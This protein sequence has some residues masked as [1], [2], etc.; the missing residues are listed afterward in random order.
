MLN[1]L[2]SKLQ[3][4]LER[5]IN[6]VLELENWLLEEL[7]VNA[8]IE[9]EITSS[10]IATYRDTNDRNKRNLHMYN[11]NT[12]QP[13]LK[14]YN[15]KFDQKF[16]DCPFSD[17]LDEQKYGFM[18]KARFVKSEM[19][20]EKNIALSVKE[21][22]LITKYREIMSNISI[23]WEG[24]QKTYAYV[25]A[26]IDNPNRAIREKAWYALCEARSI[27]KIE[28]DCIMKEL[29]QLRNQMAL[30]AGFNNYSE[31]A[32]KQK[33]RDYSIE[34]CYKLHES[35]EK[36]VVPIWKQLGSISK[37]N[38]GV[39]TYR[40]WD[41]SPCH[42]PKVPFQN[43]I[44]LLDGVEEMFRTTD[45]YFYEKF[46]YIGKAE[47][48]DVEER[49]NKA[50]GAACFTLPHSKEV[51]VYSNF[52]P[53]FYA[54]NALIHELGHA[55]NFY[56][57]FNNDSSMQE[58]YLRE[59]V[60]ELYSLS[61][62]L[63]VMDKLNVFYKQEDEYKEVQRVQLYRA[64]SLLMS[65][66]AGDIFQHWL[67]ANPNHTPEERDKKYAELC[68]RYQYSSVD[69]AGLEGEIGASWIESFHYV[70]FPFYKIEY[71][72]AQIGAMQLFQI[73]REDPEKA[74]AFFKEG[75]SADWNLSIQEIYKNTGVAFDF[76]EE[77]IQSTA[78]A[79]LDLINELK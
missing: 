39:K 68:K 32:F 41:L 8:E 52:S 9:E 49:R 22:E 72:I 23:N 73:Y 6:S 3:S 28:I 27:V 55:F 54:I 29:V 26:R 50:P 16:R 59:E 60:A 57:Q 40:P 47:L 20:N 14:R 17:L 56:K 11:Q 2:E 4:L 64:L 71:A 15:A 63:L 51:F 79:I 1:D 18:K 25:K 78:R 34:D 37:K 69:I 67:Y 75:A 38:L 35:I 21:Q 5:N 46:I 62:E 44:D 45:L 13:L 36:Y 42:L 66:I 31:Y 61:L 7:R 65:S 58:R 33:N 30:N 53:S 19:F 77:R 74:I 70:Q 43:A 76:S 48:I 10:L 24:E 12:I